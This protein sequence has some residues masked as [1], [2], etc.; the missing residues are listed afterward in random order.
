M[1]K[2]TQPSII[3]KICDQELWSMAEQTGI[4]NGAGIDITDGFIHFSSRHQ[5]ASTLARHFSG[6]DNLLLIAVDANALGEKIIYEEARGGEMFPHLYEPLE[7]K[8]RL[9]SKPL[10]V[11]ESGTHIIPDSAR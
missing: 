10:G 8:Y 9:W 6:R 3:Y 1:T 4:F 7:L 11:D 2:H 5:L